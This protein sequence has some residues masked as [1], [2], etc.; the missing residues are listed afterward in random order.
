MRTPPGTPARVE[1]S[2]GEPQE[3][4]G[5]KTPPRVR[6]AT[7]RFSPSPPASTLVSLGRPKFQRRRGHGGQSQ[8]FLNRMDQE[9]STRG[10]N[11]AAER[12][13][14]QEGQ[15][16]VEQGTGTQEEGGLVDL[17]EPAVSGM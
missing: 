5:L 16:E 3:R 7:V 17:E 12:V 6:K 14:V 4:Q 13:Q 10:V 1:S 2:S 8:D 11:W 9:L 15:G